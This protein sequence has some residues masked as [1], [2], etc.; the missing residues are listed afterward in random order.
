MSRN[1]P[2]TDADRAA[3]L[4]ALRADEAP[5]R[6]VTCSALKRKY[7]DFLR[8]PPPPPP[9][10]PGSRSS[11]SSSLGDRESPVVASQV[12]FVLLH[13]PADVLRQRARERK[14]H[15]AKEGLVES[16]LRDLELP[17]EDEGE[18]DVLVV[19]VGEGRG[20]EDT[21][22]ELER[23]VRERMGMPGEGV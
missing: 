15:F 12:G 18:G 4:D 5:G 11:T 8:C 16:Q 21:L 13:V 22:R 17:Q 1:E 14:G 6:V 19:E 2:L 23:R 20:V 9:P 7:R 10:P 3:W